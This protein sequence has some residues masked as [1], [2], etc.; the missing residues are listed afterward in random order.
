MY[1]TR[2]Y[3]KT[4]VLIFLVQNKLNFFYSKANKNCQISLVLVSKHNHETRR[5]FVESSTRQ[6]F[7][8]LKRDD[9]LVSPKQA[10][11]VYS[12]AW[13][14]IKLSVIQKIYRVK[15]KYESV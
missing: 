11:R 8:N 1:C 13:L 2:Y 9:P 7:R 5:N 10:L 14:P 12:T 4:R 3:C 15:A 6:R